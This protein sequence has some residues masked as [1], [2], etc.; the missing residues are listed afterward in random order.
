[1]NR[2]EGGGESF[3]QSNRQS[4][5]SQPQMTNSKSTTRST[6]SKSLITS[7]TVSLSAI[8][9]GDTKFVTDLKANRHEY[10][11]TSD[12]PTIN[13]RKFPLSIRLN[14]ERLQTYL[15]DTSNHPFG[16]NVILRACIY[17][18]LEFY[19]EQNDIKLLS[20]VKSKFNRLS[21]EDEHESIIREMMRRWFDEMDLDLFMAGGKQGGRQ[22][23]RVSSNIH[24]TLTTIN[25]ETGIQITDLCLISIMHILKEEET[26]LMGHRRDF[27]KS[28]R[29]FINK[30][31][32]R[33][34]AL[35]ILMKE[36]ELD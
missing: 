9:P 11:C 25:L 15:N 36:F 3:S 5:Q 7:K 20:L 33:S 17:H 8:L 18:G 34:R 28:E 30:L 35:N 27:D 1:M 32:V 2:R 6:A 22:T 21:D 24:N 12:E 31:N 16:V 4:S 26:T 13:I 10:I 14:L 23:V 19:K 29:T